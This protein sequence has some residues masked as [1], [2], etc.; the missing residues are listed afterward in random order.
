MKTRFRTRRSA[1]TPVAWLLRVLP[2]VLVAGSLLTAI[3][4]V[5]GG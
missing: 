1:R 5:E 2:V 3:Q 4:T